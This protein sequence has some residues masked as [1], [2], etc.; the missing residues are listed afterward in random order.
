MY[1]MLE[2]IYDFGTSN[3]RDKTMKKV[4]EEE[5]INGKIERKK[6]NDKY[7][8]SFKIIESKPR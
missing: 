6:M 3:W 5:A 2:I 7:F 4:V 1:N 8:P